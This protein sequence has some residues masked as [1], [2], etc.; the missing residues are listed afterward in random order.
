MPK[1]NKRANPL[2]KESFLTKNQ[3]Q[4]IAKEKARQIGQEGPH[5]K[6]KSYDARQSR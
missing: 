6:K 3:L 4:T 2:T 5:L 1:I